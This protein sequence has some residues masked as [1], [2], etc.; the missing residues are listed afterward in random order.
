MKTNPPLCSKADGINRICDIDHKSCDFFI[1]INTL[2]P[3][4][5]GINCPKKV[6]K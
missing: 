6:K 2:K 1:N 5:M 3:D 4:N